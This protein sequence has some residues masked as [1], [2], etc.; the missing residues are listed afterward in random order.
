MKKNLMIVM[1]AIALISI[2]AVTSVYAFWPFTGEVSSTKAWLP[3][4]YIDT[5]LDSSD[6]SD[7]GINPYVAGVVDIGSTSGVRDKCIRRG[8]QVQEYYL[9]P[10]RTDEPLVILKKIDC[11]NGCEKVR[12][13][14]TDSDGN[15]WNRGNV[16]QCITVRGNCIEYGDTGK[17]IYHR[18]VVKN[19]INGV[20]SYYAD[21]K[22]GTGIREY[23]CNENGNLQEELISSCEGVI[24]EAWLESLFPAEIYR[25]R[26]R[27]NNL[28]AYCKV[29]ESTCAENSGSVLYTN[30]AGELNSNIP[31][32]TQNNRYLK[33]WKC[34]GTS[35][36]FVT[37]LCASGCSS[38]GGTAHCIVP[39]CVDTDNGFS[40][41]TK[42]IVTAGSYSATDMCLGSKS[43]LEF[44]CKSS[45]LAEIQATTVTCT[46]SCSDGKCT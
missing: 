26:N 4:Q 32:C 10:D 23:W 29:Y 40:E 3:N 7:D 1:T 5:D 15:F 13:R 39:T 31:I 38:E 24:E 14:Y 6:P 46:A 20:T 33:T 41:G 28:P 12:V 37:T 18:G 19:T 2:L 8:T 34:R 11:P 36:T 35:P 43:L 9:N 45:T 25:L 22:E 21:K 30:T 44:K 27:F 16:G 17:D 42:G